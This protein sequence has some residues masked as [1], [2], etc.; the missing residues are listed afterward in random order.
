M[1]KVTTDLKIISHND[2]V[3]YKNGYK[4]EN[5]IQSLELKNVIVD[6]GASMMCLSKDLIKKLKL[7]KIRIVKV[8][9]A[10]D[11]IKL[12]I[13]GP[14]IYEIMERKATCEVME[15]KHPK[16]KALVGQIPLEQM[17][18]LINPSINKLI[19]NYEHDGQLILDQLIVSEYLKFEIIKGE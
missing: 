14:I 6:S 17:D 19:P 4:K 3:L 1:G 12:G 11:I 15:L 8:N 18:F 13:Y 5:E 10:T 7:D 16:I 9:T 2:V